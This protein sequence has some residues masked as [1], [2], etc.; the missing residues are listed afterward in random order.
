MFSEQRE[1][2]KEGKKMVEYSDKE[3]LDYFRE[4]FGEGKE[5]YDLAAWLDSHKATYQEK[6]D[7][8]GT[9]GLRAYLKAKK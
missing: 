3:L 1:K 4:N 9:Y 5:F 2:R 6:L 7:A 8:F